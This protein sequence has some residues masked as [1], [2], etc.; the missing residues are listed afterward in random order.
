MKL[1]TVHDGPLYDHS[2]KHKLYFKIIIIL[3]IYFFEVAIT[4]NNF[5]NDNKWSYKMPKIVKYHT[6]SDISFLVEVGIVP[7]AFLK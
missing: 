7:D 3:L 2:S 5:V 1:T 6:E 4:N